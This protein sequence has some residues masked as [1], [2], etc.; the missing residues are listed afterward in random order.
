M[1][2][3]FAIAPK[4]ERWSKDGL[5]REILDVNLFDVSP[6]TFP[7]YE[8]TSIAARSRNEALAKSKS[9]AAKARVKA[10]TRGQDDL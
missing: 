10:L 5:T 3:A 6:V 1:S 4:G 8:D 2:F 9:D 7:A